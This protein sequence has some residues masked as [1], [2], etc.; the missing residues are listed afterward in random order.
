MTMMKNFGLMALVFLVLIGLALIIYPEFTKPVGVIIAS[1]DVDSPCEDIMTVGST[2]TGVGNKIVKTPNEFAE[3]TKNLEGVVTFIINGN[4]R[5]CNIQK[6]SLLGVTVT[7]AGD[8]G[9]KLGIDLWGGIYYLFG[10]EELSQDLI[11]NIRQRSERYGLS[12]IKIQSY[13]DTFVKIIT[14]SDEESYVNLLI[15][16]G[17]LEGRVM[18]TIDFSETTTKFMFNDN[19]YEVSL[20][21]GESVTINGSIYEVGGDFELDGVGI[22]VENISRNTTTLSIKIFDDKD[23]T[24]IQNSRLG[25]SRITKQNGG[26]VFVVPVELSDE[27]SEDYEKATKNLEVLVNPTTSESYSKYPISIFI[28]GKQFIDIP[29]LSE[30]MGV[31]KD[32]LILWGY[33]TNI[34]EATR[35]MVR[36]KTI[37]EMKSLPGEL[38]FAERGSSRSTYGEFLTTLLL[39]IV[40]IVSVITIVLFFVKFKK[41]GITSLP[42]I[43][44]VLSGLVLI[45]G[46]LSTSWFALVIFSIG[47][48]VIFTKRMVYNWKCWVGVFFFFVL[49]IGMAMSKWGSGWILD[50]PFVIGLMVV[51]L[52]SFGQ[53]ILLGMR[54]LTKGESY[55]STDY[56][57]TTMKIWLFSTIFAFALI[58]LYFLLNYID[59]IS[60]N[61]IMAVSIGLWTNLSLITAVYTDMTKKFIK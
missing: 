6:E 35:N 9:I 32:D 22:V 51:V 8:G 43:L 47:F 17:K 1:V 27:A 52:I 13:N 57:N 14:G 20:K 5:S 10:S 44:M 18:E 54:I 41:S 37:I 61:F 24:L 34:E 15:E 45:F 50:T 55:S 53:N 23:L 48:M 26:Y 38:T 46:V 58:V 60:A 33:S 21:N 16:Q 59:F 19:S 11:D 4:P 29:M 42:L 56:K 39:F 31:K 7:D 12:N 2:I 36:L 49:T 30:D 40:L 25:P 28:D 3:L